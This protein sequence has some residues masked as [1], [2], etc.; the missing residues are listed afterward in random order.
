MT[1]WSSLIGKQATLVSTRKRDGSWVPTP[2]TAVNAGSVAYFLTPATSGKVKRIRNFPDV[3]VA[4][5]TFSGERTGPLHSAVARRLEGEELTRA[6]SI[7]RRA[8]P[9]IFGV[10]LRI[11]YGMRRIEAAVYELSDLRPLDADDGSASAT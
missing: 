5:A 9:I 4:S 2:V 8:H 1:E 6:L 11:S 3:R 7:I 10:F